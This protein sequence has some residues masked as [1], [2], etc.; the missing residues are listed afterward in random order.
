MGNCFQ[1]ENAPKDDEEGASGNLIPKTEQ[2]FYKITVKL[3]EA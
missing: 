1:A 2:D 3:N